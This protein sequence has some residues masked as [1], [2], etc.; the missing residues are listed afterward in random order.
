MPGHPGIRNAAVGSDMP[1]SAIQDRAGHCMVWYHISGL[2]VVDPQPMGQQVYGFCSV[3]R[4]AF[5]RTEGRFLY[6]GIL[7]CMH[8][9]HAAWKGYMG[10]QRYAAANRRS[11]VLFVTLLATLY[12]RSGLGNALLCPSFGSHPPPRRRPFG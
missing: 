4:V 3:E 9:K 2:V 10:L 7:T 5:I 8:A 12:I 6:G 1:W 11:L